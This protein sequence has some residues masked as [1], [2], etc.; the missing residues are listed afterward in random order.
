MVFRK[1]HQ[2][3]P[4]RDFVVFPL[5]LSSSDLFRD[6]CRFLVHGRGICF[7]V[8]NVHTLHF[9]ACRDMDCRNKSGNDARVKWTSSK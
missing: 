1:K 7:V 3:V 2:I 4:N 6:P 5:N 8:K 9:R